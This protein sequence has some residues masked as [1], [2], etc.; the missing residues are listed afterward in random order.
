MKYHNVW[1]HCVVKVWPGG[2]VSVGVLV[3]SYTILSWRLGFCTSVLFIPNETHDI[4][5]NEQ[6][7]MVIRWVKN[8]YGVHKDLYWNGVPSTALPKLTMTCAVHPSSESLLGP[9]HVMV[10]QTWWAT[11][12]VLRH[13]FKNNNHLCHKSSLFLTVL[14]LQSAAGK[15][16]PIQNAL[17]VIMEL[18]LYS[19][20]N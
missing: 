11:L 12:E 9:Y 16:Y 2:V 4:S 18:I 13:W 8:T 17:D 14:C 5:N 19:P 20:G 1:K 15:C 3:M 6:L 10:H 7:S